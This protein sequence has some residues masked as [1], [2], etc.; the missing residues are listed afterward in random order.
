MLGS[1]RERAAA[2]RARFH[3]WDRP[4][5]RTGCN[6]PCSYDPIQGFSAGQK[7]TLS[8]SQ[9]R[10]NVTTQ[11]SIEFLVLNEQRDTL[12]PR[13][14]DLVNRACH[15]A[16]AEAPALRVPMNVEPARCRPDRAPGL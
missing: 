10:I 8:I 3:R 7:T 16:G 9:G 14:P 2:R 15:G 13:F 6:L 4:F 1:T 12:S 5:P 11:S